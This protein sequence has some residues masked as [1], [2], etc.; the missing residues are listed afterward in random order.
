MQMSYDIW[1][2]HISLQH[3]ELSFLRRFSNDLEIL[4][5]FIF[6]DVDVT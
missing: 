4:N 2:Q 1:W 6:M 3:K 5:A